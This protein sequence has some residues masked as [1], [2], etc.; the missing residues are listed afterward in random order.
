MFCCPTSKPT[1]DVETETM[2]DSKFSSKSDVSPGTDDGEG[3][4]SFP[5]LS[6]SG[7]RGATSWHGGDLAGLFP[8]ADGE[9]SPTA[10]TPSA[11]AGDRTFVKDTASKSTLLRT[12]TIGSDVKVRQVCKYGTECK[13][14]N[15]QHLE[16]SA[17]PA[18]D[19]YLYQCRTSGNTPEF[20][21]VRRLFDWCD[22]NG[23]GKATK[24]EVLKVWPQIQKLDGSGKLP[25]SLDDIWEQMDDDGNGYINFGEL[26]EFVTKYSMALPLGLDELLGR[27]AEATL[28]CGV[29]DCS[30]KDFAQRRR[31]CKFGAKCY[32]KKPEHVA[33]FC[34]PDDGEEYTKAEKGKDHEMCRCGHKKKMHSASLVAAGAVPYPPYW[35]TEIDGDNEFKNFRDVVGEDMSIFQKLLN[36][37]YSDVTTRDRQRHCGT[38]EVP[39]DFTLV[40]VQRNENS[41][42]WRK[43]VIRKA[44]MMKEV[45]SGRTEEAG[46]VGYVPY[47]DI[48]STRVWT[49][50]VN[51]TGVH[52][53]LK[54]E[55]NEWYLFH[56]TSVFAAK[57]ICTNDFK[58][59]L[60]G[61]NT[62]TLYGRGTYMAESITKADEYSQPEDKAVGDSDKV[63][64]VLLCRV[65]G[66]K[67]K[68]TAERTPDPDALTTDCV[69]GPYDCILGD[70][71]K[72]SGTYREVVLFDAENVYPEFVMRYKRGEFFK[73]KSHP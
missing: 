10:A 6:S 71:T 49:S 12:G 17:H 22:T 30:C 24:D 32:Q 38:W 23:S 45:E 72:I 61:S 3:R 11:A 36:E 26:A 55:I 40:S 8:G 31:R 68:Y 70:R 28:C 20:I 50:I 48:R 21:S 41:K 47:D 9:Y 37:T 13:R 58:M 33:E 69:E 57:N 56:G 44:E 2:V 16:E 46:E 66:G 59:R 25:A 62:G 42:L 19:D 53:D 67:V 64:T 27:S 15:P 34:H 60:A 4:D 73:S 39:R 29:H 43:Y 63:F 52:L 5:V 54:N 14:K 7:G 18:D 1:E 51:D 65:L 35:T